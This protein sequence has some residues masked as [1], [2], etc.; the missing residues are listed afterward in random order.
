MEIFVFEVR[1]EEEIASQGVIDQFVRLAL[2]RND[3]VKFCLELVSVYL[4]YLL[5]MRHET[6]MEDGA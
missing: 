3:I 1:G 4:W 6:T 2:R 5:S